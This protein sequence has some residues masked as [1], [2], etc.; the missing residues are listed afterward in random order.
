MMGISSGMQWPSEHTIGRRAGRPRVPPESRAAPHPGPSPTTSHPPHPPA[1][2]HVDHQSR[3][4]DGASHKREAG[5]WPHPSATTHVNHQP[6]QIMNGGWGD[7]RSLSSP[8]KRSNLGNKVQSFIWIVFEC[9]IVFGFEC[10]YPSP[11]VL[12]PIAD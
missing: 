7:C 12:G 1:T 11:G 8:P 10:S 3:Q 2:T 9:G 6:R 5:T 4:I